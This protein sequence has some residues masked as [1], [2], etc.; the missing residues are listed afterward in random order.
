M[1]TINDIDKIVALAN[2]ESALVNIDSI[3][4]LR[5][6]LAYAR[7]AVQKNIEDGKDTVLDG[8]LQ[9]VSELIA[10]Y[11][12]IQKTNPKERI[13]ALQGYVQRLEEA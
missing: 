1:V 6:Q 5:T 13:T 10:C 11:E 8:L 2:L 9:K 7:G 3:V 4:G 12:L